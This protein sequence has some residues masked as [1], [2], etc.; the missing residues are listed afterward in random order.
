MVGDGEQKLKPK[1]Q[2]K[3]GTLRLRKMTIYIRE[4]K[5]ILHIVKRQDRGPRLFAVG[6]ED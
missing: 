1:A 3:G 5:K 4:G 6:D 2:I